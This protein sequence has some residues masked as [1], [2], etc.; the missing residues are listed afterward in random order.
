MGR[1]VIGHVSFLEHSAVCSGCVCEQR[2]Q[3]Q[4]DSAPVP[5]FDERSV[6][7][8]AETVGPSESWGGGETWQ[9]KLEFFQAL[10][11]NTAQEKEEFIKA[12]PGETWQSKLESFQALSGYTA[13]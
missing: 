8:E 5:L 2:P 11:G 13:Q 7:R 1:A 10:P 9:S 4:L 6:G 12:L 3:G